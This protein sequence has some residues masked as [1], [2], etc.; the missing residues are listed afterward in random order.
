MF[1]IVERNNGIYIM[2]DGDYV[3]RSVSG[4]CNTYKILPHDLFNILNEH[5]KCNEK[6][7]NYEFENFETAGKVVD[8]IKS[9]LVMNKLIGE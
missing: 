9:Y 8:T 3:N 7:L 1:G 6:T 5:G 2:Y 4:I